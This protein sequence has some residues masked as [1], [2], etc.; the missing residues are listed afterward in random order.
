MSVTNEGAGQQLKTDQSKRALPLHQQLIELGF[1]DFV[2][3]RI[4]RT[5]KNKPI[6]N[7]KPSKNGIWSHTF[8]HEFGKLL[9]SLNFIAGKRPTAYLFRHTIIDELKQLQIEE[10]LVAQIVGHA[11]QNITYGRYDKK[12]DVKTLKPVVDKISFELSLTA[13]RLK[14]N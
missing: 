11:Y 3:Q 1:M 14:L 2:K 9:D 10:S 6:F 12:F 8:C 4:D 5:S 7:Y 13:Q